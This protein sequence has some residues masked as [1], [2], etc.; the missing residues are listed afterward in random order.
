[1][2]RV[3]LILALIFFFG[4]CNNSKN[5]NEKTEMSDSE[6][7]LVELLDSV[8]NSVP[9]ENNRTSEIE[10]VINELPDNKCNLN[11]LLTVRENLENLNSSLV[12]SLF[13]TIDK[14]CENNVE[15]GEFSNELLFMVLEKEPELFVTEL[16]K[17]I[18]EI[19]TSYIFFDLRNPLHDLI[20]LKLIKSK[21]ES[22]KIENEAK[23]KIVESIDI[24]IG[25]Y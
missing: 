4:S 5:I 21:L 23:R 22:V 3:V 2:T 15:F 17:L 9:T 12:D 7:V 6:N 14:A 1:M 10:N 18:N 25:K 20:D 8:E 19:D 11:I 16:D 24:A 13:Y